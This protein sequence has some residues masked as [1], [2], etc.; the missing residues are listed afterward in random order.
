MEKDKREK[1]RDKG[2]FFF[3]RALIFF[4]PILL[5]SFV[6]LLM[7]AYSYKMARHLL[8]RLASCHPDSTIIGENER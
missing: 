5:L 4:S 1:G 7:N 6:S 8:E 2:V 3:S